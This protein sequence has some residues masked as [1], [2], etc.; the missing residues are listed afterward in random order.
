MKISEAVKRK[1]ESPLRQTIIRILSQQFFIS[2]GALMVAFAYVLFQLPYNLAAGGVSGLGVIV[3]HLIGFSPGLFFLLANIPLFVLGFFALGRWDFLISSS[4]AVLVFSLSTEFF[5]RSM[6]AVLGEFP[7]TEDKLLAT[8]FAG[9]LT[10]IGSGIIYRNGGTIGG[11]SIIARIIY[12]RSGYPMSQ[13]CL[14]VDVGIILF[15]GFIFSWETALLAFLALLLSGMAADYALEG[16]SQMRTL[17][18]VTKKPEPLRYAIIHEMRRGVSIWQVQGG[19]SGSESSL[20][21]CTILRS[22]VYDAK[23][24]INRLDPD[25]FTVV[26]VSQQTW[27]GYSPRKI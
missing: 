21:Y 5:M 18:I 3:N 17:M 27:G 9:L 23:Y 7:V 15:A 16:V 26:G 24:I 10:G 12:K 19:F 14:Y 22:R 8:I 4:L 20:L 6:P 13:S 1:L 11:T 25:A 2:F